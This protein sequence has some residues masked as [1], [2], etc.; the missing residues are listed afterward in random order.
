MSVEAENHGQRLLDC[1]QRIHWNV[2]DLSQQAGAGYSSDSGWH[3]NAGP[4]HASL[5]GCDWWAHLR[6][7]FGSTDRDHDEQIT[8]AA[9]AQRIDRNDDCR[10]ILAR[11]SRLACSK[12]DKPHLPSRRLRRFRR[13]RCCPSR[14]VPP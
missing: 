7:R 12:P 4:V 6:F 14:P 10:T 11:L 5:S 2:A 13:Q 9:R 8:V 1:L 3:S